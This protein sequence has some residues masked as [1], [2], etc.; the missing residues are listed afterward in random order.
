MALNSYMK[1]SNNNDHSDNGKKKEEKEKTLKNKYKQQNYTGLSLSACVCRW[2]WAAKWKLYE[3]LQ[4]LAT[5]AEQKKKNKRNTKRADLKHT[6]TF[7][8]GHMHRAYVC[9]L[10]ASSAANAATHF[11][12]ERMSDKNATKLNRWT[13][14]INIMNI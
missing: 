4:Q 7:T 6:N 11:C 8:S 13:S 2:Q 3:K 14:E 9:M 1:I 5:L 12:L 10:I